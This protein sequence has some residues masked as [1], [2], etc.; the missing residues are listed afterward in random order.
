M[1]SI[2]SWAMKLRRFRRF[3]LGVIVYGRIGK[4]EMM[5]IEQ[6]K[7]RNISLVFF[8]ITKES[9]LE[10]FEQKVNQCDLIYCNSGEDMAI[11]Y[12][13][14]IEALGKPVIEPSLKYYYAEDKWMFYLKCK[15]YSIPTPDTILLSENLMSAKRKLNQFNHWP[16]VLK[17][18]EGTCGEYV[19]RADNLDDAAKVIK[20]LWKKATRKVPIIAQEFINSQSYRVTLIG[21]KIAQ[22]AKKH[23]TRW[24]KTGVYSKKIERFE[25]DKELERV[26]KR[27]NHAVKINICGVDLLKKND[28]WVVLEVNAQPALDFFN[29]EQ[30]K[31]VGLVL[32]FLKDYRCSHK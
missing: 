10:E 27:V 24:K 15:R 32:D 16:V 6:A 8:G 25:I 18:V 30:E 12:I 21:G 11:E 9:D 28:H 2:K 20:R 13:K 5:F 31:M 3:T 4:E 1:P 14:T 23:N 7:K 22:V 26:V 29:E 19:D 17:A